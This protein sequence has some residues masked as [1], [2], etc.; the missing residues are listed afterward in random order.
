MT[1]RSNS[2][3]SPALWIGLTAVLAI[4][5]VG[6][7]IWGVG[8]KSDLDDEKETLSKLEKRTA[9]ADQGR[10]AKN[11]RVE[12]FAEKEAGRYRVVRGKLIATD[13]QEADFKAEV[14]R[15]VAAL[16]QAQTK[17][18]AAQDSR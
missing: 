8:Q 2:D 9:A 15:E 17:L 7:G 12:G 3:S 4:A 16:Q 1:S 13:R 11:Q 6:L 5:A 14:A 18:T 10:A